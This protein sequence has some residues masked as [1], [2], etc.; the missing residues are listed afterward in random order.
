MALRKRSV[1]ENDWGK[2]RS[3]KE[4]EEG[5][6]RKEGEGGRGRRGRIGRKGRKKKR[7]RGGNYRCA[8]SIRHLS[9]FARRNLHDPL[10]A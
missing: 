2:G 7:N 4:D 10:S 9:D 5:V 3:E 6:K 8:R 1:K